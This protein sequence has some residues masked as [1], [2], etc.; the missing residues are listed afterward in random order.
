LD[1]LD[2]LPALRELE[3]LAREQGAGE[4]G[5][6]EDNEQGAVSSV[7][8]AGEDLSDEGAALVALEPIVLD[9]DSDELDAIDASLA[10][11]APELEPAQAEASS[12]SPDESASEDSG[13]PVGDTEKA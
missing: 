11:D 1:S 4:E 2:A 9:D 3:E 13:L 12:T 5:S 6:E 8:G 7:E 10:V